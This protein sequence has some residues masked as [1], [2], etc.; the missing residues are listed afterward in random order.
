MTGKATQPQKQRQLSDN[1]PHKLEMTYEEEG[2][3]FKSRIKLLTLYELS[4]LTF[5]H[6]GVQ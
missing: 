1:N 5:N 6:A 3:S 4:Q 2:R